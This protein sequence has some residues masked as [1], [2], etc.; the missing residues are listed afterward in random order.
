LQ[1][2]LGIGGEG[3]FREDL[4]YRLNV[5][6]ITLP[7]LRDRR[8]DISLLATSFVKQFAQRSNKRIDG[9]STAF[10]EY[11]DQHDWKGNIRELKNVIERAII[12]AEDN[13][14]NVNDLPVELRTKQSCRLFLRFGYGRKNPYYP[15]VALCQR[16]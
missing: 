6:T 11:L 2:A 4:F 16:K 7:A 10:T 3:K 15:R 13:L 12:L 9:M 5:F 8:E 1:L 14:L